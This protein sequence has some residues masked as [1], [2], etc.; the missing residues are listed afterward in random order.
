MGLAIFLVFYDKGGLD[1]QKNKR[2]NI[3]R[4][5]LGGV[6][7]IK[8]RKWSNRYIYAELGE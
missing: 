4:S 3:C 2:E 5:H 1:T 8:K 6:H 7:S